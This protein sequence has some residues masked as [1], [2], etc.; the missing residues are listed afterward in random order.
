MRIFAEH[1][2]SDFLEQRRQAVVREIQGEPQ[3]HLLN[4]NEADYV[5]YLVDKYQVEPVTFAFDGTRASSAEKLI[6]AENHP[7]LFHVRPGQ[8]YS[9]QAIT[10]HVP[11]TGEPELLQCQPSTRIMW[12]CEVTVAASEIQFDL[13]NWRNDPE[14][15]DRDRKGILHSITQ[16]NAYVTEDVTQFNSR[17]EDFVRQTLS[18]RKSQLPPG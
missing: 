18:S 10:L 12:T 5:S 9:R 13:I 14:A 2:L 6:A 3:D 11:F 8:S 7:P 4:V 16:Q 15:L 1:P 17:L